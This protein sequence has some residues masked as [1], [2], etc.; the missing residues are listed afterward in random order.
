MS[1]GVFKRKNCGRKMCPMKSEKGCR[2]KCYDENITYQSK[3]K[4]CKKEQRERGVEDNKIEE[5]IYEGETSRSMFTRY[6]SH[7]ESFK[8]IA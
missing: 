6:R 5:T 4:L 7:L 8:Q 1:K 3:C 2:E